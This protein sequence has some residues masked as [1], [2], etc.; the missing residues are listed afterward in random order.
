VDLSNAG[1]LYPIGAG[2]T[3]AAGT[4]AAWQFLHH[5]SG[6]LSSYII[7]KSLC[8]KKSKWS[9]GEG[10][11]MSKVVRGYSMATAF[12][13]GLACGSAS[14]LKPENSVFDLED[15]LAFYAD[16]TKPVIRYD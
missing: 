11:A 2:D 9:S 6:V 14:C 12:A 16:M 3:V 5:G 7:R 13:F 1:M 10:D 4:L 8:E 15:A